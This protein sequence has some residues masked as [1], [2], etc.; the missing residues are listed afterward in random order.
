MIGQS[1]DIDH[2]FCQQAV[3]EG[4]LTGFVFHLKFQIIRNLKLLASMWFGLWQINPCCIAQ[5]IVEIWFEGWWHTK[6]SSME[7]K[8]MCVLQD[9]ICL[10][11]RKQ[12]TQRPVL[13]Q[14][15]STR[16]FQH[17]CQLSMSD[18]SLQ[19]SVMIIDLQLLIW[20]VFAKFQA[21]IT[22]TLGSWYQWQIHATN[23]LFTFLGSLVPKQLSHI[24]CKEIQSL[25][26]N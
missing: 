22:Q 20:M 24:E 3:N 9:L 23:K 10:H 21:P 7:T 13:I 12:M 15:N 26:S 14:R 8:Q 1:Y 2:F 19:A 25:V 16:Y 6:E 11:W 17:S 5:S 4:R 18:W